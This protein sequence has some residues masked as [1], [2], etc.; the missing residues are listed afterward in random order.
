M[1]CASC[2]QEMTDASTFSCTQPVEFPDGE[3]LAA[4]PF[5]GDQEDSRCHDC[6]VRHGGTHHPGCDAEKCPRCEGQLISCGCLR[7]DEDETLIIN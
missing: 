5:T 6:G 2:S 4:V 7:D 1:K 3:V